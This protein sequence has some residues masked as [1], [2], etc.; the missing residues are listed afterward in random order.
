MVLL[1]QPCSA[2]AILRRILLFMPFCR[3]TTSRCL[4]L[5][6]LLI[7]VRYNSSSLPLDSFLILQ[8]DVKDIGE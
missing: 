7:D 5:D 8:T 6:S 2:L 4:N 1:D 3:P